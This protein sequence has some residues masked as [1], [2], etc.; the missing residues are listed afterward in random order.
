M[1]FL[2]PIILSVAILLLMEVGRWLGIRWRSQ[3]RDRSSS[4]SG[5]VEGCFRSNGITDCF[6]FLRS[7]D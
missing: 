3:N 4:G 1:F 2:F 6:H 5:A 7:R